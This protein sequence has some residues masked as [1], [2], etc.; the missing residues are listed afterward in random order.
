MADYVFESW[1]F[2]QGPSQYVEGVKPASCLV[3]VLHYEVGGE[4]F[5]E[6]LLVFKWVVDLG[7]RH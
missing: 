5:F 2:K 6:P 7:E 4:M 3:D 1:F